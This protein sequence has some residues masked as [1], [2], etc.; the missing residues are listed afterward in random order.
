MAELDGLFSVALSQ[1]GFGLPV[2]INP[3]FFFR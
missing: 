3:D 1:A 2:V